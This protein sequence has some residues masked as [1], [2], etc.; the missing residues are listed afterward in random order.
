MKKFLEKNDFD[1]LTDI[2]VAQIVASCGNSK[3]R[4]DFLDFVEKF[5]DH[6]DRTCQIGHLTGSSLLVRDEENK[7]LILFHTII[8]K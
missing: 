5:P 6:L 2:S 8:Q 3:F 7:I 4:N 1:S